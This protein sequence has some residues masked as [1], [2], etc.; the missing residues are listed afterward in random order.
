MAISGPSRRRG[1]IRRVD[2][3]P[4]S[5][6]R[7]LFLICDDVPARSVET[8]FGSEDWPEHPN[9]EEVLAER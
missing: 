1:W 2:A 6:R 9:A 4:K 8:A 7:P 5:G 3:T